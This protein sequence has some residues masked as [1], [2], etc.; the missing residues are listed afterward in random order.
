MRVGLTADPATGK[1]DLSNWDHTSKGLGQINFDFGFVLSNG[2]ILHANHYHN[3][4]RNGDGVG[5]YYP[6]AE[7]SMAK[8]KINSLFS[9]KL[10]GKLS[11]AYNTEV[12]C[13]ACDGGG[14]VNN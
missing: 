6:S 14:Y 12:W 2:K 13:V 3:P 10:V 9:W 11:P 5:D 1:V 4:D 8:I 7:I